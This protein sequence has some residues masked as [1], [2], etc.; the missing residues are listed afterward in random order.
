MK[1]DDTQSLAVASC[2][3]ALWSDKV[4]D[5]AT[6]SEY[7]GDQAD[8]IHLVYSTLSRQRILLLQAVEQEDADERSQY[9]S[10]ILGGLVYLKV[11][12]KELMQRSSKMPSERKVLRFNLLHIR[13]FP[14]L[15]RVFSIPLDEIWSQIG[16]VNFQDSG[17]KDPETLS[18]CWNLIVF[19]EYPACYMMPKVDGN[20]TVKAF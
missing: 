16:P 13:F 14:D 6:L 11:L 2:T 4:G 1:D 12:E 3:F 20:D 17:V 10:F 5:V 9:L 19:G 7:P 8:A 18:A 15:A